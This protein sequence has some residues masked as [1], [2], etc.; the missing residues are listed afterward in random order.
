M[1]TVGRLGLD[2]PRRALLGMLAATA[3]VAAC[4]TE[5]SGCDICTTSAIVYGT[6]WS[7]GGFPV[8]RAR[9]SVEARETSCRGANVN[10]TGDTA[11]TD[12]L[13]HYRVNVVSPVA[14]T[15]VC[16]IVTGQSAASSTPAGTAA[17]TGHVVRLQ[18][19]EPRDS[20]R[21]DLV[22]RSSK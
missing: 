13:G 11:T 2:S 9:V 17:D 22:L 6:V 18:P 19:T 1:I 15:A 10:L 7:G 20:V 14:P 12:T 21:V 4:T 5:P 8:A 16:L 3:A